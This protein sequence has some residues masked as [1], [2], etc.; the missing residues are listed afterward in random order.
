[1]K[2]INYETFQT[3]WID[4]AR[5]MHTIYENK[6]CTCASLIEEGKAL[7]FT[8]DSTYVCNCPLSR[9]MLGPALEAQI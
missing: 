1:M 6:G 3:S 7:L 8:V 2:T 4:L 5:Q 9:S